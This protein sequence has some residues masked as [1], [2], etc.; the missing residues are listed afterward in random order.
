MLIPYCKLYRECIL[1]IL[2]RPVILIFHR[3]ILRAAT[4]YTPFIIQYYLL[5][6]KS[7][8]IFFLE[9]HTFALF[10]FFEHTFAI[11]D[12]YTASPILWRD[13]AS[14]KYSSIRR[15]A[16]YYNKFQGAGK[17]FLFQNF[18]FNKILCIIYI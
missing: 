17:F 12:Q 1:S 8:F 15:A 5:N 6:V 16:K 10:A 7:L 18:T 9:E 3:A 11:P 14:C 2:V 13:G 4:E